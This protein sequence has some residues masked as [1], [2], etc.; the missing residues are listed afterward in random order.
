MGAADARLVQLHSVF[1]LRLFAEQRAKGKLRRGP[2]VRIWSQGEL[3]HQSS[4]GREALAK[5]P[6]QSLRS[7]CG[8]WC[9][10]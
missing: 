7:F 2:R 9:R 8:I 3:L 4:Y 1:P 6:L 5:E 10:C